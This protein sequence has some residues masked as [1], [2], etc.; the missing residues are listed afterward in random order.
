MPKHNQRKKKLRNPS[1]EAVSEYVR[2]RR[3]QLEKEELERQAQHDAVPP[4]PATQPTDP[5]LQF[6]ARLSSEDRAEWVEAGN[7]LYRTLAE[8]LYVTNEPM[9]EEEALCSLDST[10][11]FLNLLVNVGTSVLETVDIASIRRIVAGD[12]PLT[13]SM[14]L[15]LKA[16]GRDVDDMVRRT[17]EQP[18]GTSPQKRPRGARHPLM[19]FLS[20]CAQAAR[21]QE[22]L[23]GAMFPQLVNKLTR[24]ERQ[25]RFEARQSK[26][27]NVGTKLAKL[28]RLSKQ[29]T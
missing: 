13:E 16:A 29:Q 15:T 25:D 24:E 12:V 14:R 9:T 11:R 7:R 22:R 21:L 2:Q 27:F 3:A 1:A 8:S 17:T 19:T 23:L 10:S 28:D 6:F 20:L 5:D 26:L 18:A 4:E